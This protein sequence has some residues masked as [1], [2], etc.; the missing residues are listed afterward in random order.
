[1]I[2]LF[3][4]VMLYNWAVFALFV[5]FVHIS[6][7]LI[8]IQSRLSDSVWFRRNRRL[9]TVITLLF[10]IY[11]TT[12]LALRVYLLP[13]T[14]V[15]LYDGGSLVFVLYLTITFIYFGRCLLKQMK[16]SHPRFSTSNKEDIESRDRPYNTIRRLLLSCSSV[17]IMIIFTIIPA[18]VFGFFQGPVT[19]IITQCILR[20]EELCL[21]GIMLHT[22]TKQEVTN[23]KL[24]SS[25]TT[26]LS[27]RL[28][29]IVKSRLPSISR[30]SLPDISRLSPGSRSSSLDPISPLS[31]TPSIS[32]IVSPGTSILETLQ[33]DGSS[34]TTGRPSIYFS[35]IRTPSITGTLSPSPTPLERDR[36]LDNVHSRRFSLITLDAV[37][38]EE[39][40]REEQILS[41]SSHYNSSESLIPNTIS[42]DPPSTNTSSIEMMP[43]TPKQLQL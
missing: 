17:V 35:R 38:E 31:R 32:L 42:I 5:A 15:I 28:G 34:P 1:V 11:S 37:H 18:L 14:G 40:I 2:P 26:H 13:W 9:L 20:T 29:S 30:K 4:E 22:L 25:T 3:I 7:L 21:G 19:Y 10:F 12:T 36:S 23:Y 24:L 33:E 43:S 16:T 27:T 8:S 41:N 39:S 6:Q